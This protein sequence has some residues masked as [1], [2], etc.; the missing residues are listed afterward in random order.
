MVHSGFVPD[1]P[2]SFRTPTAAHMSAMSMHQFQT[3]GAMITGTGTDICS[4]ERIRGMLSR[5][6]TA[7]LQKF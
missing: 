1:A 6:G 5:H 7:L 4:I 2:F 3:G